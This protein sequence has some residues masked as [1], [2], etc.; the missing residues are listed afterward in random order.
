[1][2]D[3]THNL[4]MQL[5][6][7][8]QLDLPWDLYL[9]PLPKIVDE[10][11]ALLVVTHSSTH[12]NPKKRLS[13]ELTEAEKTQDYEK[14]EHVGDS[15]LGCIVVD[16]LHDLFPGLKQGPACLLKDTLVCN[17]TLSQLATRYNLPNRLITAPSARYTVRE[18]EKTKGSMFESHVAGVFY[19]FLK[20]NVDTGGR[21]ATNTILAKEREEEVEIAAPWARYIVQASIAA[22]NSDGIE[23]EQEADEKDPKGEEG[24]EGEER[25]EREEGDEGEE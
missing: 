10:E 19:D 8:G 4:K 6:P 13:I 16:L 18:A 12:Q 20:G 5:P 24:E 21:R 11:L 14:L 17:N 22:L 3:T 2:P 23:E 7:S 25:E 9:P 15:L 1:M